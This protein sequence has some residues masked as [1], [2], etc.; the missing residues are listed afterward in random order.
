MNLYTLPTL[1]PVRRSQLDHSP[2]VATMIADSTAPSD[3]VPDD[4]DHAPA[5]S[6][7][8]I[9]NIPQFHVG[10]HHIA[11]RNPPV[12]HMAVLDKPTEVVSDEDQLPPSPVF[13]KRVI[14][15]FR[16]GHDPIASRKS[17]LHQVKAR[18]TS[19][20]N[21][22]SGRT[23]RNHAQVA[24]VD[25]PVDT[26]PKRR[27]LEDMDVTAPDADDAALDLSLETQTDVNIKD[28]NIRGAKRTFSQATLPDGYW[29]K[30]PRMD[31]RSSKLYH[32]TIE[33]YCT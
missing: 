29:T 27:R 2:M 7:L 20:F 30:R 9:D 33:L 26:M 32:T 24:D 15:R 25:T 8:S 12:S 10:C 5:S 1:Q 28:T 3:Q 22:L 13:T 18:V 16:V 23:K 11:G 21:H 31:S 4:E 14:P 19:K 6:V 17:L